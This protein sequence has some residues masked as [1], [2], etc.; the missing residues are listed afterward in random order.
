MKTI[1]SLVKSANTRRLRIDPLFATHFLCLPLY[2]NASKVQPEDFFT[3]LRDD[4][5]AEGIR[6]AFRLPTSYNISLLRLRL[7]TTHD[8]N[9]VVNTLHNIDLRQLLNA[10][11]SVSE[12]LS[13]KT[14]PL[15]IT[16][17]GFYQYPGC[18]DNS[19]TMFGL[20]VDPSHRLLT[21]K[22]SIDSMFLNFRNKNAEVDRDRLG[23][24]R[25]SIPNKHSDVF[26][27]LA[28]VDTRYIRR[29]L[30][31]ALGRKMITPRFNI[32]G[33]LKKY[34]NETWAKEIVPER[35]SLC[36]RSRKSEYLGG[37][38]EIRVRDEYEEIA[39]FPLPHHE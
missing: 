20:C 11:P 13:T 7:E 5:N 30:D 4:E 2:N 9:S 21:I 34:K 14:L 35:L 37:N 22:E 12:S 3:K 25:R 29:R 8:L 39:S 19:T 33:F 38:K 27:A 36:V 16:C 17:T 15:Q 24:L 23:I 10:V 28:L 31:G 32:S 6:G 18:V 1:P 26:I